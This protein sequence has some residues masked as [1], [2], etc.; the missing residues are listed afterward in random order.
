ML[1][2]SKA[3]I[4]PSRLPYVSA[5]PWT[6]ECEPDTSNDAKLQNSNYQR[7]RRPMVLDTLE[8][9]S[10]VYWKPTHYSKPWVEEKSRTI[11]R[12]HTRFLKQ[13]H[14]CYDW[15]KPGG[16]VVSSLYKIRDKPMKPS[17]PE[18]VSLP[19]RKIF[20]YCSMASLVLLLSQ[21]VRPQNTNRA[22]VST[23]ASSSFTTSCAAAMSST[24]NQK[25]LPKDS[26]KYESGIEDQVQE[27]R[28][29][30]DQ[31]AWP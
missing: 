6:C 24:A 27:P 4:G 12:N 30:V 10:V 5:R 31:L 7:T 25:P 3:T 19:K 2:E 17:F 1:P 28:F 13:R 15:P 20:A 29:C 23:L 21:L 11:H 22:F 8:T 14:A 18:F 26:N 9:S 16:S